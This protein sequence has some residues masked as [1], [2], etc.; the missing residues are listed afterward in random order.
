M[1]NQP[2]K[3]SNPSL[4]RVGT[5]GQSNNLAVLSGRGL[6][7]LM[8]AGSDSTRHADALKIVTTMN[9][10]PDMLHALKL[11]YELL[12]RHPGTSEHGTA[13]TSICSA[14]SKAQSLQHQNENS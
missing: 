13:M 12:F 8:G 11:A 2:I 14:I 1:Q 9:A 6:V 3:C 7:A 10:A 5:H 4:Y